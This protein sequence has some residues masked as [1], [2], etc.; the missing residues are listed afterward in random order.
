MIC[1]LFRV[2]TIS[3]LVFLL[4]AC[5][6]L[7]D[8]MSKTE[9]I[10]DIVSQSTPM[11]T[12]HATVDKEELPASARLGSMLTGS[13]IVDRKQL[14]FEDFRNGN[15]V[16]PLEDD[17]FA[18]PEDAAKTDL[19]FEGRLLIKTG[20]TFGFT[21][22]HN[23]EK[24]PA[25]ST[26]FQLP[27]FDI[28]FVQD[29]SYLIPV[30][31]GL[32]YTGHKYWNTIIGPGRI[33][34]EK[35]DNGYARISFPFTLVERNQNCTH[36]G[37]MAFLY[38]GKEVTPLYYQIT[39]ETCLEF[40]FDLW[41]Q[42]GVQYFPESIPQAAEI[43]KAYSLEIKNRLPTKPL[44]A[45]MDDFP[46]ARINLDR[47]ASGITK[48]DLTAYGL[49]I[50]NV[51]YVSGCATR[52]G[53]YAYCEN[54]RLPS[55]STAKSAF[56][57]VAL[58]RLGQKYG[59]GV[60][61]LLVKDYVPETDQSE[62][63]WSAVT[64]KNA[65]D[66][67]TGNYDEVGYEIDESSS[68]MG[69]FLDEAETLQEKSHF[70]LQFG[71]QSPPGQVW[72]YHTSDTF[73]LTLAMNNFLIQKE[74]EGSDIFNFVRDEVYS[75]LGLSAGALSSL[76]TDNNEKGIPFGGYG[77]FFTRDDIAKITSLLN[78][79]HG[80]LGDEQILEPG[81]LDAALQRDSSDRGLNTTGVPVFKY[82]YGFWAKEW[83][84]AKDRQFAC[85]FWTPFMSGFGGITVAL[86][87]N[88]AAYYYFSDNNEFSW[89]D[90]I[91]ETNKLKPIC[92]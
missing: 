92:Q 62:G 35:N 52:Y 68:I 22:I 40:K 72:V 16:S 45:L 63:D 73:L 79:D 44:S 82:H 20:G 89:Y 58:M 7:S 57:A 23:D 28:Q 13:G 83:T 38:N 5:Q 91:Y 67:G 86:M 78:V 34:Q 24:K 50:N 42:T 19:V 56:A 71:N 61:D 80:K 55:Y 69:S 31:Q 21:I 43:R 48:K 25:D 30:K 87:P 33:W 36:N 4:G 66:M 60:Y 11:S 65:L 74:G 1:K 39:Q 12:V 81:L 46:E 27:E 77:L 47:F 8:Q 49:V 37:V 51:N 17:A 70:A 59:T 41:G 26:R 90:A 29:G 53:Q 84:P 14:L 3:I 15:P 54:M 2:I 10:S 88:G 64:F 6:P 32:I 85:S 75:P 76:R 18:I 9:T